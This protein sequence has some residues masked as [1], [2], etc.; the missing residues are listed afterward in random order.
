MTTQTAKTLVQ[1]EQL[2]RAETA[3]P[4]PWL[5]F[6]GGQIKNGQ[7]AYTW[8][9]D[10]SLPCVLVLGGISAG[11]DVAHRT[12]EYASGWWS[13]QAGV[14]CSIDF[15]RFSVLGIDYLGGNGHSSRQQ[16]HS[17][18]RLNAIDSRDQA[19]AI[20]YLAET[21]KIEQFYSVIGSSYGGM[22]TLVLLEEFPQLVR[23]ALVISAAHQSSP[24]STGIR[25]IQRE[26]VRLGLTCGFAN[27]A[28][29]LARSL[30]MVTYRSPQELAHRFSNNTELDTEGFRAPIVDYLQARGQAFAESFDP[31]AFCCLSQSID[32]H[33]VA[34]EKIKSTFT[35]VAVEEDQLIPLEL[36]QRMAGLA[37]A[38]FIKI[39]SIYGHDAFLK[40]QETIGWI[41]R[42]HLSTN[43]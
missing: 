28:L 31:E 9:G 4:S 34:A 18:A 36:I 25:N 12:T 23:Q 16:S 1:R 35:C 38:N 33:R 6:H 3:L 32:L 14:D 17:S 42:K 8:Y 19:R 22:V 30:A 39:N 20:A 5:L 15:N 21:L 40:E 41:I 27:H 11:R 29:S 7:L 43:T 13:C 10:P 2:V 26:I 37:N 24:Q